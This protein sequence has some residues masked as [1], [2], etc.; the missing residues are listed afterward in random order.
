M[1]A[2]T[3]EDALRLA[4]ELVGEA[5]KD[6]EARCAVLAEFIGNCDRAG[7][8]TAAWSTALRELRALQ[9][10]RSELVRRHSLIQQALDCSPGKPP[11]QTPMGSLPKRAVSRPQQQLQVRRSRKSSLRRSL[12]R[13]ETRQM[14]TITKLAVL[15]MPCRSLQL[16]SGTSQATFRRQ[17]I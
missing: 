17:V 2:L 4:Q 15:P 8:R 3:Q 16:L 7:A 1:N 12:A 13:L 5:L 14:P 11:A 6:T 10:S 9:D